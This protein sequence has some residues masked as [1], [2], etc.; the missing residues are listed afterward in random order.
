MD[1]AAVTRR[2][3]RLDDLIGRLEAI[4]GTTSE[5]AIEVVQTMAEVY[6]EALRR[7]VARAAAC[8]GLL[9]ALDADDLVHHLLVLHDAHPAPVEQRVERA[10][11]GVRPYVASHGGTV[12]LVGIGDDVARIRLAG[13]C[14]SC[15]SSTATLESTVAEAVLASAPELRGVEAVAPAPA[16]RGGA[17]IPVE[18]LLR[19]PGELV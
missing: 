18:A 8:E 7:I 5:M 16:E 9:E 15:A 14:G 3:S 2:L 13:S 1:E 10:L 17:V 12:E 6:G 4:P 11:D 19:R